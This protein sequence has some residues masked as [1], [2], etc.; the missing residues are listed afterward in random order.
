VG[1]GHFSEWSGAVVAVVEV[2]VV[3]CS[4]IDEAASQIGYRR[5]SLND[6]AIFSLAISVWKLR[7]IAGSC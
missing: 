2:D 1:D 3:V 5:D 4:A 7:G 6:F